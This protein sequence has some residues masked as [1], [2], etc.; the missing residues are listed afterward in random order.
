MPAS[1]EVP[2]RVVAEKG[3]ASV[4][5]EPLAEQPVGSVVILVREV[6]CVVVAAAAA[7][8]REALERAEAV[9]RVVRPA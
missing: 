8:A 9:A 1:W 6:G 7:S 2:G 5:L 3:V 4:V